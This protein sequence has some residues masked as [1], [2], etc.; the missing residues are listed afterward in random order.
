VVVTGWR[1]R[2]ATMSAVHVERTLLLLEVFVVE[3]RRSF[4]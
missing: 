3:G 2:C 4:V 1:I